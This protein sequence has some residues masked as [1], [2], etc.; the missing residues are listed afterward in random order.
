MTELAIMPRAADQDH[1]ADGATEEG[2]I[3][4]SD[5]DITLAEI[6]A[7]DSGHAVGPA[8]QRAGGRAVRAGLCR[9]ISAA[10][11]R[12]PFPRARIGLLLA[13]KAYG[14]GPDH[15]VVASS[16][17]FR[18]TIHAI[19]HCRCDAGIRGYRLLVWNAGPGEGRGPHHR[20]HPGDRREQQQRA[21]GA[22]D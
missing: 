1:G 16:Y 22:M 17:S 8:F 19:S 6:D 2:F 4:L 20:E 13:L 7:V 9:P 11:T 10:N 21:S 14:I 12:L 18:E 5:P 15:E 3:A